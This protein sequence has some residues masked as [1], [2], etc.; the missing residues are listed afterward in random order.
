MP[1]LRLRLGRL[2]L[3]LFASVLTLGLL[4]APAFATK[5]Y[6]LNYK[7]GSF[8]VIDTATNQVLGTPVEVG[9]GPYTNAITPN[10]RFMY[11]GNQTDEDVV[12]VD[13][14]AGKLVGSP[15]L[16]GGRPG[17]VAI[18]P[19]GTTA[20]VTDESN[21][22]VDVISTQ[23]NQLV[24]S[25]I[26]LGG[27]PWG[28]SFAPDGKT[29]YVTDITNN[30]VHVIDTQTR[31][32]VGEPIPVGEEPINIAFTPNGA[33]AYVTNEESNS[34]SVIDTQT[35]QVV[36]TISVG[37]SPWEVA[38]SPNGARAYVSNYKA[39]SVSVIDT[40][41]KQVVG[42][43][44]P[45]GEE[46]YE[47]AF[48]PD[49]KTA[50]VTNY[51]G[52]SV[53]VIDAQ[54]NQVKTTIPVAGGP[55]QIAIVPDQS[56]VASFTVGAATAGKAAS[57]NGSASSDPDGS[58]SSFGWSFGDGIAATSTTPNVSHKYK[59]AKTY[60]TTL[61]ATDNEGCSAS[62]IFTGRTAYC[63]GAAVAGVMVKVKA[64]NNFKFGKLVKNAGNGT[65]KLEVKVPY[66]GKLSLS[67]KAVRSATLKAGKAK[68]LTLKIL[69]KTSL[70]K[71]LVSSH[72][73]KVKV[74]VKFSPTGGKPRT[75]S[76]VLRLILR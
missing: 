9:A 43:P 26:S 63:S 44:I 8:S 75:K 68:T 32:V 4:A 76:K 51:E 35:R 24:G 27:K 57:F 65:A 74:R 19:D 30:T 39:N 54:T 71:T 41:T 37:E 40:Q 36:A 31:Q 49:G 50:Y 38:I 72:S 70:T 3:L 23:T 45:T 69:P 73:A 12:V 16:L 18:S 29:A 53:T 11:V 48:T 25:P 58:I 55:W 1:N 60:S 62:M 46:P 34:V 66:A 2:P 59:K 52:E 56:P 6:T 15:I 64:P 17:V 47:V 42:S 22:E 5:A 28:I 20:Y 13:L 61:T 7:T 14:Q 10:G 67:G 33:F 21:E